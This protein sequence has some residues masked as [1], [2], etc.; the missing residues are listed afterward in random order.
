MPNSKSLP[1]VL[2]FIFGGS[3]DLNYRKLTPALYNL[4]LDGAM[5]QKFYI[6]GIA[7]SEYADDAYKQHL[8]EGIENFSR[9]K[10][11]NNKWNEFASHINYLQLD[12]EDEKAY[13]KLADITKQ[14][15]QE[16]GEHPSII[17]YM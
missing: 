9:R 15:E 17:F 5:P 13:A 11:E 4:F 3:G 1:P 7:R 16:S 2:F 12:A 10:N 8:L 14:K 6:T